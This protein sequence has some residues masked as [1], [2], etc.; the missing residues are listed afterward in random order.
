MKNSK[1]LLLLFSITLFSCNSSFDKNSFKQFNWIEYTWKCQAGNTVF[2]EQWNKINDH[3]YKGIN[4]NICNGQ[5]I[6]ND[7]SFIELKDNTIE[8]RSGKSKWQLESVYENS[9]RFANH[10]FGE[11]I[12]YVFDKKLG[13]NVQL[14]FPNK[15]VSYSMTRIDLVEYLKPTNLEGEYY[16]TADL[17][18]KPALFS[19]SFV[20]DNGT[21]NAFMTTADSAIVHE[22]ATSC[23]INNV[24][25]VLNFTNNSSP[26]SIQFDIF[27]NQLKGFLVNEN[28]FP[29]TLEKSTSVSN[30]NASISA[31]YFQTTQSKISCSVVKPSSGIIKNAILI[32][33]EPSINGLEGYNEFAYRAA[34]KG[35]AVYTYKQNYFSGAKS[36]YEDL[37][38]DYDKAAQEAAEVLSAL[39]K[40]SLSVTVMAFGVGNFVADQ[41]ISKNVSVKNIIA[42]SP[43][44]TS[45]QSLITTESLRNLY[46]RNTITESAEACKEVW[47][48]IFVY[49][50]TGKEGQQVQKAIDN[51]W[52]EGWGSYCL[53][54]ELPNEE[55]VKKFPLAKNLNANFSIDRSNF[56][57]P[58]IAIFGEKDVVMNVKENAEALDQQFSAKKALLQIRIYGNADHHLESNNTT[59]T[60]FVKSFSNE[61]YNDLWKLF[62]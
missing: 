23:C 47:N 14:T 12:K 3:T 5:I 34:A 56:N 32:I 53:P 59:G 15:N 28:K 21:T 40:E 16:G 10:D 50:T 62:K 20:N 27:N 11:E 45:F 60:T 52:Q 31:S 33:G 30:K 43:P 8:F 26:F 7:S 19:L 24:N 42:V 36:Y 9:F 17:N 2:Y 25:S 6:E 55:T 57:I 4:F 1:L 51:A 37:Y 38:I 39:K 18:G 58:I 41:L 35:I 48:A 61:L 22:Q 54:Q 46:M 29:F 13:A 49:L 44:C